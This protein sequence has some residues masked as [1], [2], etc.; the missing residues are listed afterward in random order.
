[1]TSLCVCSNLY[2]HT[3]HTSQEL[4]RALSIWVRNWCLLWAY[5]SG[6]DAYAEHTG[7]ELMRALIIRVRNWFVHW[8]HIWNLKRSLQNMLSIPIRN[9]CVPWAYAPGTDAYAEQTPKELMRALSVRVR[10]WCVSSACASE[11]KWCLAPKKIKIIRLYFSPK[12]TYPDRLYGVKT[13]KIQAIE[14]LTLGHLWVGLDPPLFSLDSTFKL[15]S[16]VLYLRNISEK[17]IKQSYLILILIYA[18]YQKV[19]FVSLESTRSTP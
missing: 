1:M 9:W 14:N 3:E 12:V 11:V 7:Q 13:T 19:Q 8:A 18:V 5:G 4:M 16:A 10:N 17:I 15:S 6:T 2:A